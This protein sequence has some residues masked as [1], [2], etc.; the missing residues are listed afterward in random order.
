MKTIVLAALA[1]GL[2]AFVLGGCCAVTGSRGAWAPAIRQSM[3]EG[4]VRIQEMGLT[5]PVRG[6]A[7]PGVKR[8]EQAV[9]LENAYVRVT[10]LPHYA[11]VIESMQFKPTECEFFTRER[12]FKYVWPYWETGIKLSFPFH[13]HGGVLIDQPAS[14]RIMR[15]ADGSVTL[16]MWMEFGRFNYDS[17][18]TIHSMDAKGVRRTRHL[19]LPASHSMPDNLHSPLLLSQRVTLRPDDAKLEVAY[20]LVNPTPWRMGRKFWNDAFFPRIHAASGV[21]HGLER[22]PAGRQNTELI[23][24][25]VH[26]SNHG[27]RDFREWDRK[28]MVLDQAPGPHHSLFAW[29]A[30]YGF[31]GMW[32]PDVK[33]N[34]LRLTDISRAPGTKIYFRGFSENFDPARGQANIYNSVEV[35]G[36]TDVLFEGC[37]N[38]I[39][40]GEAW[41][42]VHAFALINGIG[43]VDYADERVAVNVD[44]EGAEPCV[45]V[46]SL[47]PVKAL[48][49]KWDDRTLGAAPCA[50]DK[51]ARFALPKGAVAG[52]LSLVADGQPLPDR[53]FPLELKANTERYERIRRSLGG[54]PENLER[55][56]CGQSY[57]RALYR[58]GLK[59]TEYGSVTRGRILLRDGQIPA[60]V[61][62]LGQATK[63]HPE[64]GEGWHLLGAALL[65]QGLPQ[66]AAHAFGK[67]ATAAQAYPPARYYAAM[68]RLAR[69]DVKQA[70]RDLSELTRALP[71]HWEARLLMAWAGAQAD[72]SR[73][74]ALEQARALAREDPADP[75]AAWVL[76]QCLRLAGESDALR[77][78]EQDYERLLTEPGAKRRMEEFQAATRGQYVPAL[79]I[80]YPKQTP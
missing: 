73:S 11:G 78:A 6:G 39:E 3:Q 77:S 20:R 42:F 65:E 21:V 38:W 34:R 28:E 72:P 54:A 19:L 24:P 9:V 62:C 49:A 66:E 8:T 71:N 25:T 63:E 60:A 2:A 22:P 31:F 32:Y 27:A 14:Y 26:L 37:E 13:E 7:N 59:S 47:Q 67:A 55:A 10:A 53:R 70:M 16:A 15:N 4:P 69:G 1:S 5:Y 79:R 51:P 23:L 61:E 44:L 74:A 35:W 52:K 40:P 30:P 33:V 45:E 50:P 18:Q 29:D 12:V 56:N 43:K 75:R 64:D 76:A 68:L 80:G 36:G 48:E 57:G 41:E 46:V 58:A 17:A